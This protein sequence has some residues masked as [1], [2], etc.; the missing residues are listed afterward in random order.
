MRISPRNQGS[1][2]TGRSLIQRDLEHQFES[3]KCR[4]PILLCDFF[5]QASIPSLLRICAPSIPSSAGQVNSSRITVRVSED[6]STA[7]GLC[8]V[9]QIAGGKTNLRSLRSTCNF[10]S[11]A[12][13][14]RQR[15]FLRGVV[16]FFSFTCSYKTRLEVFLCDLSKTAWLFA[17]ENRNQRQQR[18]FNFL[19]N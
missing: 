14:S 13:S 19:Q 12:N 15:R 6:Q 8:S 7:S 3:E 2:K 1:P 10:Q 11:L 9:G 4:S 18:T 16:G 17:V 5:H